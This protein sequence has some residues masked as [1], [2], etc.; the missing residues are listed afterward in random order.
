MERRAIRQVKRGVDPHAILE[1]LLEMLRVVSASNFR[2]DQSSARR[3]K[4]AM[5]RICRC[6]DEEDSVCIQGV[7]AVSAIADIPSEGAARPLT[8]LKPR[9]A[10]ANSKVN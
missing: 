6:I 10:L 4:L 5:E 7:Q 3:C 8:K 9:H 2:A 1:E